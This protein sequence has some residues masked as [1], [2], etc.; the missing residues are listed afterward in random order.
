MYPLSIKTHSYTFTQCMHV[1]YV[2]NY[3]FTQ[4]FVY[5]FPPYHHLLSYLTLVIFVKN[6]KLKICYI[7]TS[8]FGVILEQYL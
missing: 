8:V 5:S 7:L 4:E 1:Y 6:K 2:M 3:A